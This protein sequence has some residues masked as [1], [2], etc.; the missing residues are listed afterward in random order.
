M[1]LIPEPARFQPLYIVV[2]TWNRLQRFPENPRIRTT[3][4]R[5]QNHFKFR[6]LGTDLSV[7][8]LVAEF[9]QRNIACTDCMTSEQVW[10]SFFS[11]D[12]KPKAK[13][14]RPETWQDFLSR[15]RDP[16][17]A[18]LSKNEL[19]LW[20]PA[21]FKD[22]YR[23]RENVEEVTLLTF[24]VDEEPIPSR[25]QL[26]AFLAPFQAAV[27]SSSS[28]TRDQPR[29]RLA[30]AI[31]RPVTAKEYDHMWSVFA[32]TLPFN[33]GLQSKDPSRG[34]Y[35]PRP[36][37]DGFYECF[38][39]EGSPVDVEDLLKNL[40][41]EPIRN[42][43]EPTSG[44]RTT[45]SRATRIAA[46]RAASATLL[47]KAWPER[48]RHA[49]QLAL[50]GALKRDGWSQ[51]D[52]LEFLCNVCREAGDEDRAKR[53][54]TIAATWRAGENVTGWSSLTAHVDATIVEDARKQLN[55]HASDFADIRSRLRPQREGGRL[56]P[57]ERARRVGGD[58]TTRLKTGFSTLDTAT[59]GGLLMK[60][61]VAIG[62]APGAGKTAAMIALAFRWLEAGIP[63]AVLA[64]DEDADALLIRFGQLGGLSRDALEAGEDAA[65]TALAA[66]CERVPL[67]LADGDDEDAT[68][69]IV[70]QELAALAPEQPRVL[71]VDSMQTVRSEDLPREADIRARINHTVR[72]LKRAAKVDGHLVIASSEL[73]KAAYRNRAQAENVNAL[74]AF[75]ESGDIEYGVAL[76]LVLVSR[77]GTS[78]YVDASVVKNRLGSGK[79]ELLLKLDHD[80]ANVLEATRLEMQETD[81]LFELKQAILDH[82]DAAHGAAVSREVL[83]T[84]M[85]GNND[86]RLRA[87]REL[88]DA[89][90][91]FDTG[92]G[93]RRPL[94]G[95]PG[96]SE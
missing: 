90:A 11:L 62:G 47:G 6:N 60:K 68:I 54:K 9:I 89:H 93:I 49:A 50:A 17:P 33:V 30:L 25:A 57:A 10:L 85:G 32:A 7:R 53:E 75:K 4:N 64:A 24:D 48:G 87:I 52:A 22:D 73:S 51:E 16:E 5:F 70:S 34:W 38:A 88:V 13:A 77:Q 81:P 58:V 72:A 95:E 23:K 80:R 20:S 82:V 35:F 29:W 21:R 43:P 39:T 18:N 55:F 28:A 79:P 66:W 74:S 69:E 1:I 19:P 15:L 94:P 78:D 92:K 59:R 8:N 83:K 84:E 45:T 3:Q 91:L 12:C 37:P 76:A 71:I 42:H 2:G 44:D 31:S 36:G 67:I 41:P 26:E 56:P 14:S 65:R 27:H 40:R 96:Y 46:K 86:R 61:L 63:V